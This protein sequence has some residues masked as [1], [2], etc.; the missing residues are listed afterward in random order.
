[1]LR[2]Q[3]AF[4]IDVV[5]LLQMQ[6]DHGGNGDDL[7]TVADVGQLPRGA[8][9]KPLASVSKGRP[10]IFNST[11]AFVT[12]RGSGREAPMPGPMCRA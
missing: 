2:R 3:A 9:R 8:L 4:E 7:P 6:A 5:A 10:D 11:I 12:R 1:M